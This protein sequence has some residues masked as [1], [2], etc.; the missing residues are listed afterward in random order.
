[1]SDAA[2]GATAA[3]PTSVIFVTASRDWWGAEESVLTLACAARGRVR[4]TLLCRSEP[5]AARW[6]AEVGPSVVLARDNRRV[7]RAPR[8]QDMLWLLRNLRLL[9]SH[10]VVVLENFHLVIPGSLVKLAQRRGQRMVL[11]LHDKISTPRASRILR[12]FAPRMDAV[13]SV[14]DYVAESLADLAVESAT[15][16]RPVRAPRQRTRRANAGRVVGIVGRVDPD[17]NHPLVIEAMSA[18][19]RQLRLVIRGD[20]SDNRTP[21]RAEVQQLCARLLPDRHEIQGR[22]DPARAMEG[23]DIL[24]VANA[25]EAMGR[26]VVE[27]QLAGVVAV[28]P[29]RGGAA[30]LVEHLTTGVVYP[31]GDA[32]GLA[33]ALTWL[34]ADAG[35][36]AELTERAFRTASARHDPTAYARA[37]LSALTG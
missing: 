22:V 19:P 11:D 37:Y 23:L 15:I 26:T 8:L 29:D 20:R 9:L 25:Q 10:D 21:Y 34:S 17:K 28:V 3:R 2:R 12:W 36:R 14:S 35:L 18:A 31:A 27:A 5:L 16:Y 4:Q 7:Q 33:A 6:V 13:I 24:V 30:E 1:M 32:R